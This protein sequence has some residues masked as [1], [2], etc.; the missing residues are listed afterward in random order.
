M[1][2]FAAGGTADV[3][4]ELQRYQVGRYISSGEA[5]WRIFSFP[6]HE[7]HPT[8]VHSA[9]YLEN[10]Q[11]VYFTPGTLQ[12]RLS[13]PPE[14][15]LTAFFRLCEEDE[16]AKS[17]LYSEV[18]NYY[19]WN[20]QTKRFQ[21][22]KQGKPVNGWSDLYSSD[23]LGRVYTVSPRDQECFFLRLLLV[24]VRGPRSFNDL[25]TVNG[26]LRPSFRQVCL[27]LKLLEGDAHWDPTMADAASTAHPRQIRTMFAILLTT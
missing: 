17:L 18:P 24:N 14:T 11:R 3:I 19:T 15:T 23:A 25:R 26:N 16:F 6:I 4:D 21:R 10:G 5:L 20:R 2:V 7:R 12:A 22:R 13:K 27:E 9:V 8:V 1:A